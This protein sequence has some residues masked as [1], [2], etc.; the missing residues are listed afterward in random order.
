VVVFFSGHGSDDPAT[1]GEFFFVTYDSDPNYL[2]ATGVNMNQNRVLNRLDSKRVVLIADACYAGNFTSMGTKSLRPALENFIRD[3]SESRGRVFF[4]SSRPDELSM[5]K[6]GLKNSVFTHYLLKGLS[7]EADKDGDGIVGIKEL[8]DYVYEKTR[9]ETNH[10]QHPQWEAK[11]EGSF[12]LALTSLQRPDRT[13]IQESGEVRKGLLGVSI[14]DLNKNLAAS[15]S[16]PD[17]DGALILEVIPGS[18]AEKAGLTGGDIVLKLND[19]F[20]T[21][22]QDLTNLVRKEKP[23][24]HVKLTI[25]RDRKVLEISAK[26]MERIQSPPELRASPVQNLKLRWGVIKDKNGVCK[27]IQYKDKTPDI[28]AGPFTTKEAALALKERLCP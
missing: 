12:P 19:E 11:L 14:Q 22:A 3:F 23:R 4:T 5:E 26:L 10:L 16:R 20:V 18:P 2:T 21:C 28:I 17:T 15:F 9:Q 7:G 1:P 24:S 8:Y 27:V 13:E 6:P 25:F